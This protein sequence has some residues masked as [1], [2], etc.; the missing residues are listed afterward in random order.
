MNLSFSLL[1]AL[2]V[3]LFI[4]L[5]SATDGKDHVAHH[6]VKAFNVGSIVG[7]ERSVMNHVIPTEHNI[8]SK[9]QAELQEK[10]AI[11]EAMADEEDAENASGDIALSTRS[12]GY[13][14][15][16]KKCFVGPEAYANARYTCRRRPRRCTRIKY[17]CP[18]HYCYRKEIPGYQCPCNPLPS[19]TPT[20]TPSSTP[21]PTPTPTPV[22][23]P[24]YGQFS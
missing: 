10:K 12:G 22:Y 24:Y 14:R 21:T 13:W 15:C 1:S 17:V 9:L 8:N 6:T 4:H 5:V 7:D 11:S 18:G 23:H 19:S 3:T 16:P 20:P 2:L